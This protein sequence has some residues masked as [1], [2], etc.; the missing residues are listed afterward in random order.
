MYLKTIV[1][2]DR[3]HCTKVEF[4]KMEQYHAKK[5]LITS[6]VGVRKKYNKR[7]PITFL[8]PV[9]FIGNWIK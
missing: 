9:R 6:I 2:S 1:Y 5:H 8:G 3:T 4:R 7:I